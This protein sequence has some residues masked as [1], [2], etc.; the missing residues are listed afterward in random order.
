[1]PIAPIGEAPPMGGGEPPI[2]S[3]EAHQDG[4]VGPPPGEESLWREIPYT[5]NS[6]AWLNQQ[7]M[8]GRREWA[9][10]DIA[11]F[12]PANGEFAGYNAATGEYTYI[13]PGDPRWDKVMSSFPQQRDSGN[14]NAPP[15]EE[16]AAEESQDSGYREPYQG[17][18]PIEIIR[19]VAYNSGIPEQYHWIPIT[20]AKGESGL[21]P[22]QTGDAGESVGLFMMHARGEGAGKSYAWRADPWNNAGHMV[23]LIADAINQYAPTANNDWDLL[24]KVWFAAEKPANIPQVWSNMAAAYQWWTG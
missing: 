17:G 16:A 8:E 19:E 2:V 22:S 21:N 24:T 10:G 18:D 15:A 14:F 7:T 1:V 12:N 6:V 11:W 23:P 5:D 20:I 4:N 3:G 9:N 13:Y